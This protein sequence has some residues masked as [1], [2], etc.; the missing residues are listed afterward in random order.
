MPSSQTPRPFQRPTATEA[1][2]AARARPVVSVLWRVLWSAV[3]RAVESTV[4]S[5]AGKATASA[6]EGER[7]T[8]TAKPAATQPE[9]GP[10]SHSLSTAKTPTPNAP[11]DRWFWPA[12]G[13]VSRAYSAE[14]A[15]R[16]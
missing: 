11:V 12:E 16:H 8:A 1:I 9:P 5:T 14:A 15:Q 10:P 4:E 3:E 7:V 2:A 13:K 6:P